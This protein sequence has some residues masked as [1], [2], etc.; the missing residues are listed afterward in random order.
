MWP[1]S[2]TYEKKLDMSKAALLCCVMLF[3]IGA[4]ANVY[5]G[6][7]LG[8]SGYPEFD[9]VEPSPPMSPDEFSM[10][11]YRSEVESYV[12]RAQEYAENASK[13][14]E[15]VNEGSQEALR[16]ANEAVEEFNRKA[17]GY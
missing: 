1:W 17:R 6:S 2:I 8:Y 4:L 3:P 16:K 12:Q 11:N 5:G 7:N 13:D 14:I 10:Q 9:E 15:R